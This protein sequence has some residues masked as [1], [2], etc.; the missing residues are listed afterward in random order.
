VATAQGSYTPGGPGYV[1]LGFDGL[2]GYA[3]G[4]ELEGYIGSILANQDRDLP[5]RVLTP[6]VIALNVDVQ[7]NQSPNVI[8]LKSKGVVPV[9]VLSSASFDAATLD[10]A[11]FVLGDPELSGTAPVKKWN[12][13]DV[14]YDGLPDLVLKFNTQ[15]LVKGGA[16][17]S[18]TV[19]LLLV[20]ETLDDQAAAGSDDVIVK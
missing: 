20:G 10:A 18:A 19:E 12:M 6:S 3:D 4:N 7:P 14:N 9:A 17:N 13:A 16:I 15:D 2:P 8:S 5:F 1:W 11:S